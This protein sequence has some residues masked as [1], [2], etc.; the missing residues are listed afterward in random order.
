[1]RKAI[2]A[3]FALLIAQSA[4]S[5]VPDR[6]HTLD[7]SNISKPAVKAVNPIID[8]SQVIPRGVT[9]GA[10]DQEQTQQIQSELGQRLVDSLFNGQAFRQSDLGKITTQVEESTRPSISIPSAS[11]RAKPQRLD[12]EIKAIERKASFL[13]DGFISTRFVYLMDSQTLESSVVTP[14]SETTRLSFLN[15]TPI[16]GVESISSLNLNYSW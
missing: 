3:T 8:I 6:I 16:G 12:F 15:T 7:L 5:S 9:P 10:S 1:M 4:W 14:I 2:L 11:P 13:Y